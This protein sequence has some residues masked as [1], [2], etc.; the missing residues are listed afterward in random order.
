MALLNRVLKK[1]STLSSHSS[2]KSNSPLTTEVEKFSM[3]PSQPFQAE[4]S[5]E[6]ET[7]Q[8][9]QQ[10][11]QPPQPP[12]EKLRKRDR[13]RKAL[14]KA[15]KALGKTACWV[16]AGLAAAVVVPVLMA[17]GIVDYI[18]GLVWMIIKSVFKG[19]GLI[20]C[21]P[22]ICIGACFA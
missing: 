16:G 22:F 9:E 20:I 1:A 7:Q 13:I 6:P 3:P 17:F 15:P 11:E 19:V 18:L 2:F 4:S 12:Q 21:L 14:R 5:T 10:Q 8:Q